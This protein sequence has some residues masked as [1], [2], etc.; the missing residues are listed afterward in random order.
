MILNVASN[1]D[2]TVFRLQVTDEY[3]YTDY[4]SL[5]PGELLV[6]PPGSQWPVAGLLWSSCQHPIPM[7]VWCLWPT[8]WTIY[9]SRVPLDP[10]KFIPA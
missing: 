10:S 6:S 9:F 1:P 5:V 4:S 7:R 8:S 2:C 3:Q